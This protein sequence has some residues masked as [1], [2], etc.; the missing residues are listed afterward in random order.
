[1]EYME[2]RYRSSF[3]ELKKTY[4]SGATYVA[5]EDALEIERIQMEGD[6]RHCSFRDAENHL[7]RANCV[8]NWPVPLPLVH[9]VGDFYGMKPVGL[10]RYNCTGVDSRLSWFLCA[11][12]CFLPDLWMALDWYVDSEKEWYGWML[13]FAGKKCFPFAGKK[14]SRNNPFKEKKLGVASLVNRIAEA[15]QQL[16]NSYDVLCYAILFR[17]LPELLVV[18][19]DYPPDRDIF[20]RHDL[21]VVLKNAS[22]NVAIEEDVKES[23]ELR[24]IGSSRMEIVEL[25][26]D[27]GWK[28]YGH[29]RYGG[30]HCKW[31]KLDRTSKDAITIEELRLRNVRRDVNVLVYVREV[32]MD[33]R[34]L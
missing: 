21:I 22:S 23:W 7:V 25:G 5:L 20:D 12:V 8:P 6:S 3:E 10:P 15:G 2:S 32:K 13:T 14:A 19:D 9:H 18:S 34:L 31:W 4:S 29:M 17:S 11:M 1:M 16:E 28:G 27:N 24:F 30:K 33:L 26:E